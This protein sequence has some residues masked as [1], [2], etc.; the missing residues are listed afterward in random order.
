MTTTVFIVLLTILAISNQ[1]VE[2]SF[3]VGNIRSPLLCGELKTIIANST[4]IIICGTI[5]RYQCE[6]HR[7]ILFKY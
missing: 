2:I 4:A 6:L 5:K 1:T 7:N 3:I